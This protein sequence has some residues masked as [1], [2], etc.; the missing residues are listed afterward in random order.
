MK[1]YQVELN[2]KAQSQQEL[3]DLLD[4][5]YA[6]LTS[7]EY[8]KIGDPVSVKDLDER[9][10]EERIRYEENW[11]GE[12]EHYIFEGKWSDEDSWGLDTA[13]KLF[14]IDY[15]GYHGKGELINYQALTKIRELLKMRI[16]FYFG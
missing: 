13:F 11:H 5:M 9:H 15:K 14:D 3:D 16:P 7:K 6:P 2:I 10:Y 12:G 1:I 8:E 4:K